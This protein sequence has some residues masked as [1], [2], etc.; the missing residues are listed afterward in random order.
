MTNHPGTFDHELMYMHVDDSEIFD[1]AN[2]E[3]AVQD[4][5]R[6]YEGVKLRIKT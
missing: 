1:A 5:V 2:F 6:I 3:I 4:G